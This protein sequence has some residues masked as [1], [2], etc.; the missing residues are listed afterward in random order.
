MN[1]LKTSA[2]LCASWV[3][4]SAFSSE[5]AAGCRSSFG[6]SFNVGAPE[7]VVAPA[8]VPAP[9]MVAPAPGYP[10]YIAPAPGYAVSGYPVYAAPAYP[11]Y[12]GAPAP[13]VI[14]KRKKVVVKP[15]RAYYRR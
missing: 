15:G 4:L 5:L 3:L 9:V 11:Y 2:L 12:Y 1:F 6:V 13:V 7:V 8:P 10:T 14:E